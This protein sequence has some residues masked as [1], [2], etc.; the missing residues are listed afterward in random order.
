[1]AEERAKRRLAAILAADV[2]GYSRER[3]RILGI[4]RLAKISAK[5]IFDRTTLAKNW[6]TISKNKRS[7]PAMIEPIWPLPRRWDGAS[8]QEIIASFQKFDFW[9]YAFKFEGGLKFQARQKSGP[10]EL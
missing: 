4:Q 2:V 9:H 6:L 3:S 5:R 8:D 10:Y 7:A 1:M